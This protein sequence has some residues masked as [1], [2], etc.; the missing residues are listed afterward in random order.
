LGKWQIY[1]LTSVASSLQ[2]S[3]YWKGPMKL[4]KRME[5]ALAGILLAA[6]VAS[7]P[8]LAERLIV[9]KVVSIDRDRG[10]IT[11]EDERSSALVEVHADDAS[12]LELAKS[13][14]RLRIIA[15]ETDTGLKAQE[16]RRCFRDHQDPTGIRKRL[17]K[18]FHGHDTGWHRPGGGTGGRHGHAPRGH[19]GHGG[20]RHGR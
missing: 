11:L 2:I 17:W 1:F 6:A 8:A 19:R 7:A 15:E 14:E 5:M 4:L 10:S 12:I 9:G 18:A 3:Y 13:G 16:A 20:G